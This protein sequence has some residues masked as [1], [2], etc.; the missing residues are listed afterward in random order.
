MIESIINK[1]K[2]LIFKIK[3]YLYLRKKSK[4]DKE[5]YPLY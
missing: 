3:N 2:F 5:I 1:F 4:E